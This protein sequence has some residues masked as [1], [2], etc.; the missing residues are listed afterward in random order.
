MNNRDVAKVFETL[1][2]MLDIQ[3]EENK[4]KII[5]YRRVAEQIAN[6]DRD[7]N[8]LWR[9]GELRAIPGV[10]Q[11]IEE[12]ID[13]LLGRGTFELYARLQ[14]QIPAGVV[15]LL[16][17]PDMGPK[18][19]K[20]LW[21]EA[22]VTSVEEL[23]KRARAGQLA[24]LPGLGRKFEEKI[25][26]NIEATRRRGASGRSPLGVAY[27]LANDMLRL[28]MRVEGVQRASLAGSLRRMR[29]TI[30]DIDVLVSAEAKN[31]ERIMDAFGA[32]PSVAEVI[33]RGPTKSSVRL[34]TGQQVD[35]RVI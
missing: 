17:I 19:A 30:G 23:E 18:R 28:L 9:A 27:P 21:K 7:L 25:V 10:G 4:F 13:S 29:E 33:A 2:D 26:A 32:L 34:H 31:A 16:A 6:L 5:A 35:L 12:K 22:G 11:A 8:V 3:G 20:L 24:G 1:A 15:A 14:K